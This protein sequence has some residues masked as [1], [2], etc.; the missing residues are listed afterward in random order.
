MGAQGG[1]SWRVKGKRWGWK[2]ETEKIR[3]DKT[4]R[5]EEVQI[6]GMETRR[7]KEIN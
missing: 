7:E 5:E 4:S 1:K 3:G 2:E 6:I